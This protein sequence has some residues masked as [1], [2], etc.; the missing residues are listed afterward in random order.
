MR[1]LLVMLVIFL[2]TIASAGMPAFA[3]EGQLL[4]STIV[5]VKFKGGTLNAAEGTSNHRR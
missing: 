4:T 5:T 3:G 2:L 1:K